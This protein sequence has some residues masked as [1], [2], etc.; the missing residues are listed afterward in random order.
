MGFIDELKTEYRIGGIVQ[1]LIFWNVGLF[2]IPVILFSILQLSGVQLPSFDWRIIGGDDFFSISSKPADLIWK[3]WS[4]FTY[5]F[6]HSG[7]LHLF[8]NMMML[9]FAGRLFLTFFTQKQFF[10]LYILSAIFAGL[11]FILSY[12]VL[13][14]LQRDMSKMV[15]ASAA[16]MAILFSTAVYA[17]QYSVRL[18]LIG[19]VKLWHI[20]AVFLALDLIY[21]SAENTGG[22]IAHLGGALF[23][24]LYIVLLKQGTDLSKGVSAVIDFFVNLFKPRKSTPFKKVHK[25]PQPQQRAST[26]KPKDMTQKQIDEILDK[27]SKSGYDSLTKEEKDFLFKVGK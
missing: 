6:L 24:Y 10:G 9:V 20:A 7:P 17:P 14:G 23:G 3:P 18:M 15:G 5:A 25:N 19:S 4:L 22:H 26:V 12:N 21:I 8:F 13:P 16:I 11:L 27:I 2:L 1:R